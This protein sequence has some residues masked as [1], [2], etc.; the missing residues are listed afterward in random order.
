M[1]LAPNVGMPREGSRDKPV[2]LANRRRTDNRGKSLRRRGFRQVNCAN[3]A[4]L[5]CEP[6]ELAVCDESAEAANCFFWPT[7]A[8]SVI[9]TFCDSTRDREST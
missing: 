6:A 7:R 9:A 4:G 2:I 5:A 1:R 8:L 3:N